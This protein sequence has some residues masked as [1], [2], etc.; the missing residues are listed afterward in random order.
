MTHPKHRPPT[1][2][3]EM[4]LEEFLRPRGLTQAEAAH[5]MGIPA[6]RI[7]ELIKG[8]RGVTAATALKLSRLLDTTPEFW[9]SLQSAWELWHARQDERRVS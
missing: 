7:N 6:N 5:R 4:L 2:A 1:H 9:M 3:G 8:K